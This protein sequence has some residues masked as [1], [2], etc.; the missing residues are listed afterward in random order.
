LP[1]VTPNMFVQ[2][3]D[4]EDVLKYIAALEKI[5]KVSVT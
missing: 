4:L 1:L 3:T 2:P 5:H